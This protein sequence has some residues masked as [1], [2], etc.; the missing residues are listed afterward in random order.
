MGK[1]GKETSKPVIDR[2]RG[3]GGGAERRSGSSAAN[4]P[5]QLLV[6]NISDYAIYMIDPQG[7]VTNWNLGAQRFKGYT[8]GEIVGQSFSRF[9]T[10]EDRRAGLPERILATAAEVGRYESDGWRVRKDG[11][12]FWAN[13][14]VDAI[15]D[16]QGRLLGFAKITRDISER[17][18]NEEH[19]HRLAHYD[20]LTG[21]PNRITLGYRLS[22][23]FESEA[24]VTVLMLDLDGFK[25][26][27]DT[28]GHAAGDCILRAAG[29]RVENCI[30]GQGL[31]GRLGGD[32]FA[33]ILPDLADPIMAAEICERLINEFHVPFVV[34]GHQSYL[35]LSIGIA[36]G[37]NHG[38]CAEELL[39]N[40]DLAL[41]RAKAEP[42]KGY[43]AFEP[44]FRQ[45][46]IARRLCDQEL[47]QAVAAGELELYYQPQVNL[48]DYRVVGVESLLRW[49]H[50]QHGILAPGAFLNVLERGTLAPIVGDWIIREAAA[51]A[52]KIRDIVPT[53][54]RVS[55]NL[56][57]AQLRRG[58]LQSAVIRALEDNALPPEAL[59]IEI[60]ENI[61]IQQGD[62]VIAP[63]RTLHDMGVGVA[64]DDYGT[65]F[66]SLSL[67]KRFPLSRLKI[68]Q[69]FIRNL[70]SDA[71]DAAV[72]RAI[73]YLAESFGLA[74]TAEGVEHE[75]Q[76]KRLRELGCESAQ[77]YLFGRPIPADELMGLIHGKPHKGLARWPRSCGLETPDSD[78]ASA[79]PLTA[80]A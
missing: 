77:G 35:G 38:R 72:V 13:V 12:R 68:D 66:A 61:F 75:E 17:R 60:T 31:V 50:P 51:Q 69:S 79:H 14:V 63:L 36:I 6:E 33:V 16:E 54:F 55:I 29:S 43:R 25:E 59:E 45:A 30:G 37:P 41:Y 27:N 67:L 2:G 3:T 71:E 57:G 23:A 47:R 64:F 18:K 22:E 28:L 40:A 42:R 5:F 49:R 8:R 48:A 78:S 58:Q 34:D 21:L 62:A 19:L 76:R 10:E 39:G 11:T 56:F 24:P 74:V 4:N 53:S 9:L 7:I 1:M 46:A 26:V 52:R 20:S 32:E 65:G 80:S 73:A 15:H 44:C 70:R